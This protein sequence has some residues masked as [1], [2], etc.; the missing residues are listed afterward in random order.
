MQPPPPSSAP[1]VG[2]NGDSTNAQGYPS[3]IV[4]QNGT[5]LHAALS[6]RS[7]IGFDSGGTMHVERVT[8][9]GTWTGAGQ[10]RPLNGLNQIPKAGQV[11]LFT[12]AWGASTPL[13][14]NSTEVVLEPFPA[15]APDTDLTATVT[16]Q[17]SGGGTPIPAVGAVLMTVFEGRAGSLTQCRSRPRRPRDRA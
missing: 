13:V 3:G 1:L 16:G 14:A 2:I 10:R 4:L 6:T 9:V 12:P 15:A 17:A 7:S 5:M 8:F 11:M